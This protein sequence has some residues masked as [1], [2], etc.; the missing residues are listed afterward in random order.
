SLRAVLMSARTSVGSGRVIV[1]FG[2]GGDRD[3]EK[4]PEMGKI[5]NEL[6]DVAIVTS[7]NSRSEDPVAIIAD[8]C[9]GMGKTSAVKIV[10]RRDAITHAVNVAQSGD[11]V[12]V[13]GKG[14]ETVQLV[15]TAS[16]SF[17]DVKELELAFAHKETATS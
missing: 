7:D 9:S 17:S 12:V 4:R 13:A 14:H 16:L 15:G 6:A 10:N 3:R 1:V 11:V 8:I 5:A 2:C